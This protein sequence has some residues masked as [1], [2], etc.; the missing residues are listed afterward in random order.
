MNVGKTLFAQIMEFV[1]WTS[2]SRIVTRYG[3]DS[4]VRRL[5][6]TEQFRVMAFAQLTWRESLRDIEASLGANASKLYAMGLRHAPHRSTLADANESRDWRIWADLAAVLIR[7]ARKLYLDE[8]L[9][10]ELKNTVYALDSTT[11]DLCLGLFDWAPFRSTKAAVKMHTLLDLRGAI[12]AFIHISDGKMHDVQVLDLLPIEAG[13]FYVV[14]RGYLDFSRLYTLHQSAAFFVTR[15]KRNMNARR[16][17]SAPVDRTTGLV[18]DQTIALNGHYAGKNY[19]AHLRRIKFND[20]GS[21]KPLIFLTNNMTLPA[22]TIAA[23]Y[24]NRWQ[25]ELFFKWIK[26]HLRIKK[27]LGTSE[28]AVKTQIW[29]AVAIYVLVAIVKKELQ[30][31]ASLYTFLQILSVSVFEKTSI[32]C[33]LQ[34]Y[35]YTSEPPDCAKQLNLFTF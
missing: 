18:C 10:L 14:D 31:K 12:P 3:G 9:G 25:V 6:C 2:F 7:R 23:L 15:A 21:G 28:N 11:I 20:P 16:V 34:P 8:D 27:F 29:C 17:Y 32:S 35:A 4:G 13:A 1:P 19:P 5:S 30:L 33:A 24:K 26:Q 22:L